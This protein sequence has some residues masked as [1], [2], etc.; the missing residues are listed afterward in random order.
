ISPDK[1]L[2]LF[3]EE[4][5][6]ERQQEIARHRLRFKGSLACRIALEGYIDHIIETRIP[7]KKLSFLYNKTK[8]V[9]SIPGDFIRQS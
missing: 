3:F 1:P 5:Q 7:F 6:D 4:G 2:Q 8:Q 9:F